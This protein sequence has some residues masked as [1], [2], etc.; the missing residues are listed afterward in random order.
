[1]VSPVL[2][3]S[4]GHI[5]SHPDDEAMVAPPH[6]PGLFRLTGIVLLSLA[7]CAGAA[8]LGAQCS[9]GRICAAVDDTT[10][11]WINGSQVGS[12]N[13]INWDSGTAIG[14]ANVSPSLL[15]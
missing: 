13:Y 12:M 3:E 2:K 4:C 5:A 9:S 6:F 11:I 15:T 1:M 14:C 10:T 8:R 7:L